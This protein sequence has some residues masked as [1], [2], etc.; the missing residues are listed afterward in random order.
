MALTPPKKTTWYLCILLW[1]IGVIVA[2]G[3]SEQLYGSLVLALSGIISILAVYFK[4]M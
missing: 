2:F 1:I 4:N 3:M